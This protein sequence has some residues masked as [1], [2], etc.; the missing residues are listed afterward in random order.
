MSLVYKSSGGYIQNNT[1]LK[2]SQAFEYEFIVVQV[3]CEWSASLSYLDAI[4][5]R[6]LCKS[7]A[8]G[9]SCAKGVQV[10][11]LLAIASRVF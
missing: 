1:I 5:L 7:T 4:H 11:C 2:V 6:G 8:G 3:K 10:K 9:A